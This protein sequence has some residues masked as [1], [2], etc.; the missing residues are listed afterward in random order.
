MKPFFCIIVTCF[1]KEHEI[2]RCLQSC[3]SQTFKNFYIIVI[4]DCSTDNSIKKIRNIQSPKIKIIKNK[5]NLGVCYSRHIA[6]KK[7]DAEWIINLDADWIFYNRFVL[8]KLS[9]KILDKKNKDI[10]YFGS[11]IKF[12]HGLV[13]PLKKY[14]NKLSYIDRVEMLNTDHY[15]FLKIFKKKIYKKFCYWPK[16]RR[17]ADGLIGLNWHRHN[18]IKMLN[19]ISIFQ[20]TIKKT[21]LSR[22]SNYEMAKFYN[23]IIRNAKHRVWEYE[24]VLNLHGKVLKKYAPIYYQNLYFVL[25]MNYFFLNKKRKGLRNIIKSLKINLLS[26]KKWIVL[27]SGLLNRNILIYLYKLNL[28][29][30]N[31]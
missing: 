4:D 16:N 26:I 11:R 29:F 20:Y 22:L 17:F 24:K 30:A 31:R 15:D 10:N 19:S 2:S 7:S 6:I 13:T 14:E 21:S 9:K 27:F 8:E 1:N 18:D 3:I 23:L 12:D 5:K 28:V 25:G